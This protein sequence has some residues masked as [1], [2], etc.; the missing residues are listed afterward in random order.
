[1]TPLNL[2]RDNWIPARQNGKVV[3]IRPC[4]IVEP[5]MTELAW[6]RPDF[7]LACLEFLIG[8]VSM[9][10]PPKDDADWQSRLEHPEAEQL[11]ERFA[12]FAEHFNL[13]GN[14]PRFLQDLEAFERETKP[15]GIKPVDMLFIDSAGRSTVV[16]N[17]D[18]M[19]KRNRFSSL[20]PAE[21]AMALYT[22]QAFAPS[23]GAGNRTSMR[24]GGPMTTLVKPLGVQPE[25]GP[26]WRLVF[27]NVLPGSPLA[28]A[29]APTALP[30]LRPTRTSERNKVVTRNSTHRLEVFFGMPRRLRLVFEGDLVK[31]V[32]QRPH[33]TNYSSW[34]HPLTPYYRR[35]EKE[36]EWL[37]VHP[38][39]GRLSYRNWIGTTITGQDVAGTHRIAETVRAY[40]NRPSAPDCELLI[41]GW[42]M[43]NMKP[44]D[45]TLDTYPRFPS[46]DEE[47]ED[48]VRSLVDAA[49]ATAGAIR[50]AL[51]A[52]CRFDGNIL[53]SI[54]EAF[55]AETESDFVNSVR[56][57]AKGG[58]IEVEEDWYR[59]M[60]NFSMRMYDEHA[61]SSLTDHDIAG[62]EKRVEAKRK[63]H[64]ALAKQVRKKLNL[65]S[66]AKKG[67]QK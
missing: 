25:E 29:H 17:A 67:R 8:L 21:A 42:A 54:V 32:V 46:L 10:C 20:K 45:F 26:L 58:S 11:H 47:E 9:A 24:G 2:L 53:D 7:N 19:V 63:L 48:R 14:G 31:G 27:S 23:G 43:N 62:I 52:G 28:A 15:S 1:M 5:G 4:Q 34:E 59:I 35:S 66:P 65:P 61:L 33:G 56:G 13:G 6:P 39:A 64:W 30:W 12:P 40:G 57:L 38:N 49:N 16:K 44:R 22:L 60:R 18:L 55:F 37:P 50:K 41:G 3:T 36:S 51:R